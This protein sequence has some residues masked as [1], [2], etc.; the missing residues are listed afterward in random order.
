MDREKFQ[1]KALKQTKQKK[2]KSAEFLMVKE[3]TEAMEGIRNPA[4]SMSSPDLSAYQTSEEKVIRHDV[5]DHTLAAHQQKFRL[6]ASAEPK[7]NEYS[8]NYFDP[9]MDE[10]INPRQCGM[11]VS[12]EVDNRILYD[13]LM[14]LYDESGHGGD[15]DESVQKEPLASEEWMTSSKNLELHREDSEATSDYSEESERY[16]LRDIIL[17]GSSSLDQ[18]RRNEGCTVTDANSPSHQESMRYCLSSHP[19]G[20]ETN[21]ATV[22]QG[23]ADVASPNPTIPQMCTGATPRVDFFGAQLPVVEPLCPRHLLSAKASVPARP[24]LELCPYFA[25]KPLKVPSSLGR[26]LLVLLPATA[27]PRSG[28]SSQYLSGPINCLPWLR[29]SPCNQYHRQYHTLDGATCPSRLPVGQTALIPG[30][31]AHDY[32]KRVAADFTVAKAPSQP[33][34]VDLNVCKEDSAAKLAT[35]TEVTHESKGAAGPC[36]KVEQSQSPQPFQIQIKCLR[37]L[38]NKV[39]QGSY[40]LKVSLLGQPGSCALPWWQKEKLKTRTHPVRHNGNFYDVGLYFH[41]S[42]YVV[43]PPKKD[44]KLG[45]AFLFELFLLRGKYACLDQ[46]VGWAAFPLCDNNFNVVEGKF[47][48]PLLR[49]HYDQKLNNFRKIEDLICLDLDH[50]L[51]NLYFQVIKLP[52]CLDDQK[53]H[54]RHTQL[55][56]EFPVCLMAEAEKAESGLAN[57]TGL[58]EKEKERNIC[59]PMDDEAK[60]SLYSSQ[61]SISNKI[62]SCPM[63]CDIDLLKED[64]ELHNKGESLND[65]SVKEKSTAWRTGE[66]EDY[67][68]D[69]SYLEELEKHRFSVCCSSV[70]DSTGSGGFLKH[71]HF[72]LGSVFSELQLAQWQ[73]QGFWYIILLMASLWFL[74]LYLHYLSQWLFLQAISAPVTKFHFSPLTVELCYPPSSLH[75]GEE[76]LVVVLGPLML[77]AMVLP[78]VLIRWGCQ[79]LFA[80]CPDVLSKLIITMGLW[81]V[82]DP[83]AV[84]IVDTILGRLTHNGETPVADAAKLFWVFERIM[85]SG[86]LGIMLTVLIYILLF[87]ISSL[88]LYLYCLRLHSDS[89]ILDAFQ[90]IHSEE[91]K[92]FIPYDSEISNQ[93]LSYIVKRSEQWRGING[94]RRKTSSLALSASSVLEF[95]KV[96]S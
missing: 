96:L 12:R 56:L 68:Q 33:I 13:R 30:N 70:A 86:I 44:V 77:N 38:K 11:E 92:F 1:Q 74:R 27:S 23:A 82:L 7:G 67:S 9:L 57:T 46:V 55:S 47:K 59:A 60:S 79:L 61:G 73:S 95:F 84:F 16:A 50:W 21:P 88:I 71:L 24:L 81:T 87:I 51:C 91:T 25:S 66:T 14:R 45:M 32:A 78:L 94:E 20:A 34:I 36:W 52:L 26:P 15:Q 41:E 40:L 18:T 10:E 75:M 93:E 53:T 31:P 39:P 58:S 22:G 90:R 80:C 48:C 83:L 49:G 2:S 43:L 62:D 85:Q 63:D 6:L 19:K 89:W 42:L 17:V 3:D 65:C 29:W 35:L 28:A 5:L 72:A 69:I 64:Q 8:R 37:G 4:F 76:L 54:G